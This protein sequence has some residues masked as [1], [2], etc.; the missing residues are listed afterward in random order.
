MSFWLYH[1][2]GSMAAAL[3]EWKELSSQRVYIGP[4]K[5]TPAFQSPLQKSHS[6]DDCRVSARL[7][8]AP[9]GIAVFVRRNFKQLNQIVFIHTLGTMFLPWSWAL[10]QS[11]TQHPV[12]AAI[13]GAV[14]QVKQGPWAG[15]F[16]E[17]QNLSASLVASTVT[18]MELGRE[19]N[20]SNPG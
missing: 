1:S 16:E 6:P 14:S 11:N 7:L 18:A 3:E 19:L 2:R 12:I 10:S 20:R 13:P 4:G 5:F 17:L 15:A 9:V 8:L